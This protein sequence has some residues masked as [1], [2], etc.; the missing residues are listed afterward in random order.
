MI[1][2][3][4]TISDVDSSISSGDIHVAGRDLIRWPSR[5][6]PSSSHE[7]GLKDCKLEEFIIQSNGQSNRP[8]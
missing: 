5:W 8:D 6:F 4:V 2:S 3:I 7:R 1:K